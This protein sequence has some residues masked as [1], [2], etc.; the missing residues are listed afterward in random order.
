MSSVC[1]LGIST[2][3]GV[4]L[5]Q[6]QSTVYAESTLVSVVGDSISPHGKGNHAGAVMVTG[7]ANVFVDG[8]PVCRDGDLASCGHPASA[9][10]SVIAN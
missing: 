6:T 2:A 8:I 4:I 3:G 1:L 7:S 5:G 9:S 10:N